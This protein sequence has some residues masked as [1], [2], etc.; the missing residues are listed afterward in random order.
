MK[1]AVTTA[2][3]GILVVAPLA[4]VFAGTGTTQTDELNLQ[5]PTS[6][7]YSETEDRVFDTPAAT[8]LVLG[9]YQDIHGSDHTPTSFRNVNDIL[10]DGIQSSDNV[11]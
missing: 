1:T 2:L 8:D 11:I 3:V 4:Y 5:V 9:S 10:Q 6:A 7:S